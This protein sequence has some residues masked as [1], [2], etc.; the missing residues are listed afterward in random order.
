MEKTLN[1]RVVI[2]DMRT[3]GDYKTFVVE[4][5]SDFMGYIKMHFT[6]V[7]VGNYVDSTELHFIKRIVGGGVIKPIKSVT[8]DDGIV[9]VRYVLE[10]EEAEEVEAEE[11]DYSFSPLVNAMHKT[12]ETITEKDKVVL[13]KQVEKTVKY[14]ID[15]LTLPM[16]GGLVRITSAFDKDNVTRCLIENLFDSFKEVCNLDSEKPMGCHMD[17]MIEMVR[18]YRK[19]C[20]HLDSLVL[21]KYNDDGS[22]LVDPDEFP[23]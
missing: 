13:L 2:N 3:E 11:V 22:L 5:D 14:G 21:E 8:D 17:A 20:S 4:E 10:A 1:F 19:L 23:F 9:I 15:C 12:A 18:D 16:V 6:K 7:L